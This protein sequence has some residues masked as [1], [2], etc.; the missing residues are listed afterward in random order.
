[1]KTI[2]QRWAAASLM[3]SLSANLVGCT[4]VKLSSSEQLMTATGSGTE[5]VCADDP[6]KEL[7]RKLELRKSRLKDDIEAAESDIKAN[8]VVIAENSGTIAAAAEF[9]KFVTDGMNYPSTDPTQPSAPGRKHLQDLMEDVGK[10]PASAI[11][12]F[13]IFTLLAALEAITLKAAGKTVARKL[14]AQTVVNQAE[15]VALTEAAKLA[16]SKALAKLSKFWKKFGRARLVISGVSGIAIPMKVKWEING[17]RW[18]TWVPVVGTMKIAGENLG[19]EFTQWMKSDEVKKALQAQIDMIDEEIKKTQ[20]EMKAKAEESASLEKDNV[21]KTE[22]I[23]KW[24][25]ELAK[26]EAALA[27]LGGGNVCMLCDPETGDSFIAT[28]DPTLVPTT[29]DTHVYADSTSMDGATYGSG[30]Y[31]SEPETY[32]SG[33]GSAVDQPTTEE[34]FNYWTLE[35]L[36]AGIDLSDAATTTSVITIRDQFFRCDADDVCVEL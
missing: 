11:G 33:S 22:K 9:L 32:G 21:E 19:E 5:L 30:G 27:K 13:G 14:C 1:M 25:T 4:D 7:K 24:K 18:E 15:K 35:E 36:L 29:F 34:D 16:S 23:K 12:K 26:V 10:F 8:D 6:N 31:A 3:L 20:D 2:H 28:A 17:D